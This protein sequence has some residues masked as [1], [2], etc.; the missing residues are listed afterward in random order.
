M[1]AE[2]RVTEVIAADDPAPE[3]RPYAN[4]AY[5]FAFSYPATWMLE[6]DPAEMGQPGGRA[7]HSILLTRGTLRLLIQYKGWEKKP[8]SAQAGTARG[9]S[10]T[11]A[12]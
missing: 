9:R 11:G 3:W 10:S 1:T 7:L 8:W 2:W 4:E 5:G 12:R 6:E